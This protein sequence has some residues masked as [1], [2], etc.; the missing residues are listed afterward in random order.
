[1]G[2]GIPVP[3]D[4]SQN[5]YVWLDALVSYL[6]AA[7]YLTKENFCWPPDLQI[8]GKDILK[9]H[10]IYWPAFL[11]DTDLPLPKNCMCT[12]IGWLTRLRCPKAQA[13]LSTHLKRQPHSHQMD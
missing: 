7:G 11:L 12:V 10:A 1:M 6:T 4:P 3:D 8:I 2:W 5:I 13:M 9:F